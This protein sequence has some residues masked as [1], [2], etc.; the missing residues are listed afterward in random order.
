MSAPRPGRNPAPDYWSCIHSRTLTV[1]SSRGP[2]LI[3]GDQEADRAPRRPSLQVLRHARHERRDGAL[4]VACTP[5]I[6]HTIAHFATEWI[7]A[8]VRQTYRHH[9][10]MA[11]KANVRPPPPPGERRY[12]QSR[13]KRSRW[14]VNPRWSSISANTPC[15]PASTGVTE[16]H[17]IN[18]CASGRGSVSRGRDPPIN[19]ATAR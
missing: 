1:P 8:P 17:R 11:G 4:H 10:G 3:A 18:D 6:Q 15:A 2:L 14:T 12:S 5:T 7:A 16:A 13:R 19:R 9:I